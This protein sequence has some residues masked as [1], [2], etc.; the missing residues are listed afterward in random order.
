MTTEVLQ[1]ALVANT[2]ATFGQGRFFYLK[3]TTAPVTV[4]CSDNGSSAKRRRFV[5][6]SAGT[7]FSAEP[8]D[9]WDY[10][11]VLSASAQAT[12]EIVIG[13]DD[14]DMPNTVSVAG[15]VAVNGTPSVI[16]PVAKTALAG[17][18]VAYLGGGTT[19]RVHVSNWPDSAD[20][21]VMTSSG[22]PTDSGIYVAPGQTGT[23]DG[24]AVVMVKAGAGGCNYSALVE[25]S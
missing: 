4:T 10:L 3:T 25:N 18:A 6:V 12:F 8:G 19:R 9:G 22:G 2:P 13:D 24:S 17:A 20:Y 15:T 14:V 11:T 7:K 16:T 21:L 5:N 1:Q 23:V